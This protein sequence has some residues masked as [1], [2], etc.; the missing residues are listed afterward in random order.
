MI[1]VVNINMSADITAQTANN[2]RDQFTV[3]VDG[4]GCPFCAYGLEKKFK[5]LKGIKN[6]K[7]DMETG[8]FTFTYPS[9]K[10]LSIERVE[11]QVDAAG[12]T[13]VST[14][15]V[16]TNGKVEESSQTETTLTNESQL[17]TE[18][19]FVAGNCGM[20]KARIEKATLGIAGVTA[21]DWNKETKMLTVS[22]DKTQISTTTVAE[23]VAEAGHDTKN[24]QSTKET[25]LN[26]PGCCQYERE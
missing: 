1:A 15:I 8:I 5:E 11:K 3:K 6:V 14:K 18:Q 19:L 4:L 24:T 23:A 17:I 20:C 22:F 26:L 16:R 9:E 21:A 25:Y 12:Y 7:I 10:E 13:P 2:N